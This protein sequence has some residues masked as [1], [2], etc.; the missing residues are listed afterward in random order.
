MANSVEIFMQL[1]PGGAGVKVGGSARTSFLDAH[2][3]TDGFRPGSFFAVQEFSFGSS[4]GVGHTQDP[5]QAK[6]GHALKPAPGPSL[7]AQARDLARIHRTPAQPKRDDPFEMEPFTFSKKLDAASPGLLTNFTRSVTYK[8]AS[9]IQCKVIGGRSLLPFLRIDYTDVLITGIDWSD[10]L[11][12]KESC[13][14]L[15][16]GICVKYAQQADDGSLLPPVSGE[17]GLQS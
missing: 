11:F 15:A 3:L 1:N 13:K 17:W 5:Q 16:R 9:M 7:N 4:G 8:S 12:V 2:Y 6:P 10:G 14:F